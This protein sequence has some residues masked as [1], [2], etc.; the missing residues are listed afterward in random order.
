MTDTTHAL[1]TPDP[2][3]PPSTP[4]AVLAIPTGDD[5]F[6]GRYLHHAP[7]P[8]A[9]AE[10]LRT[11]FH[12]RYRGRYGYEKA[13][14]ELISEHPSGW[15]R[16]GVAT[17]RDPQVT[18]RRAP[19]PVGECY[20][21]LPDGTAHP[22][23]VAAALATLHEAEIHSR[24]GVR[25]PRGD[26]GD[27]SPWKI[28]NGEVPDGIDYV[29]VLHPRGVVVK[30][31]DGAYARTGK[32]LA[33]AGFDWDRPM[34]GEQI[35]RAC[36]AVRARTVADLADHKAADILAETA[37]RLR[38]IPAHQDLVLY[39]LAAS[40]RYLSVPGE[41]TPESAL[42]RAAALHPAELAGH[43]HHLER[44]EQVRLLAQAAHQLSPDNHPAP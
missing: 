6:H 17:S 32:F 38:E 16:L 8:A 23:L 28:R 26:L 43:L 15:V 14:R 29:Y 24:G 18:P 7:G 5:G 35:E 42:A 9:T 36:A 39:L 20:C 27:G 21:H 4:G 3:D 34:P 40:S 10:L 11:L 31:R 25:I 44:A 33:A 22:V 2:A 41:H 19:A 1:P 12:I 30:V 13:V 37:R